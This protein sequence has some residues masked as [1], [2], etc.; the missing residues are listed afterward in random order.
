LKLVALL[1]QQINGDL[2]VSGA[3]GTR[4]EILFPKSLSAR[5]AAGR[6]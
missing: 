6:S 4:F 5:I 2:K 3:P 1:V